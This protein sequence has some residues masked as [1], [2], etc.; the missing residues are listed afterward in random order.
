MPDLPQT[1]HQ[2]LI[3]YLRKI[4]EEEFCFDAEIDPNVFWCSDSNASANINE[5]ASKIEEILR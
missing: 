1:R 4:F 2:K 5:I 3:A